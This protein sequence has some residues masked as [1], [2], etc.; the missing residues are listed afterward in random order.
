MDGFIVFV[1]LVGVIALVVFSMRF[2]QLEQMIKLPER[3]VNNLKQDSLNELCSLLLDEGVPIDIVESVR[4]RSLVIKAKHLGGFTN[5]SSGD[6]IELVRGAEELIERQN[7]TGQDLSAAIS[8][9]LS[10]AKSTTK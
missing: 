5:K 2:Y 8:A 7:E 3:Q 1:L 10:L 6:F 9:L 4:N